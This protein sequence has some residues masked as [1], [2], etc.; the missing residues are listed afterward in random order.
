MITDQYL[1]SNMPLHVA[2]WERGVNER[3]IELK[4]WVVPERI[5]ASV[6]N[7]EEYTKKIRHARTTGI[8]GERSCCGRVSLN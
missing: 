2:A 4:S 8:V 1:P 3:D 6:P 7:R 5:R